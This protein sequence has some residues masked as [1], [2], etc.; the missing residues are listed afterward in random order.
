MLKVVS[1]MFLMLMPSVF[2][3]RYIISEDRMGV[4]INKWNRC[5]DDI[6]GILPGVRYYFDNRA[7]RLSHDLV[8][9]NAFKT[10]RARYTNAYSDPSVEGFIAYLAQHGPLQDLDPLLLVHQERLRNHTTSQIIGT[11]RCTGDS[12]VDL[13]LTCFFL[14]LAYATYM[15]VGEI[16]PREEPCSFAIFIEVVNDDVTITTGCV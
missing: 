11:F 10:A 15:M 16:A 9:R 2:P 12:K 8:A 3:N 5:L 14:S 1:L 13:R 6:N 7:K 4:L